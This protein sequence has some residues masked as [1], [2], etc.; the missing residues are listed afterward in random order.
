MRLLDWFIGVINKR[1]K[2]LHDENQKLK[3]KVELLE[4]KVRIVTAELKD[5]TEGKENG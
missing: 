2:E 5:L 1:Q 4:R 3:A